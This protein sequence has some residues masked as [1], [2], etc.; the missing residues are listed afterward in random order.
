[1]KI[2]A[3]DIGGTKTELAIFDMAEPKM[4]IFEMRFI[5]REQ[6]SF[7]TM[8]KNFIKLSNESI[9]DIC[10]AVAGTIKMDAVLCQI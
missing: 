7:E 9:Q 10:L 5:N 2:L 3:G 6:D 8:L 1:M 4:P